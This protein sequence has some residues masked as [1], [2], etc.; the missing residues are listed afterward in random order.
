MRLYQKICSTLFNTATGFLFIN[1]NRCVDDSE[2]N[3]LN[4]KSL[5]E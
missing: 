5:F 2:I 3:K 1:L 4:Y